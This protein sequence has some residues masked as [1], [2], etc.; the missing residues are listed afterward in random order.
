[1][2]K[3]T[4]QQIQDWSN[5]NKHLLIMVADPTTDEINI[6]FNEM[7]AF[8]RFPMDKKE[9]GVIFNSL[10]KSKFKEAIDP[11]M[12]GIIDATGIDEKDEAHGMQVLH[13]LG[14]AMRSF[15]EATPVK[16]SKLEVNKKSKKHA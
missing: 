11:F 15:G 9:H 2:A 16:R 8:V 14:G 1:M 6:S 13:V 4:W 12:T 7:N 3:L 10:K 5:E